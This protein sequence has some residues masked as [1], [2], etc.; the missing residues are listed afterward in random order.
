MLSNYKTTYNSYERSLIATLPAAENVRPDRF[1]IA[2]RS[3]YRT[4]LP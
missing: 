3:Y 4:A 2:D 1:G